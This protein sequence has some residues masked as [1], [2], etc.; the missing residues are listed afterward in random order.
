MKVTV[1]VFRRNQEFATGEWSVD[2]G[3]SIAKKNAHFLECFCALNRC[4]ITISSKLRWKFCDGQDEE[5]KS[6]AFSWQMS[7]V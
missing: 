3:S 6:I 4:S 1:Q 2:G 7:G 5:L